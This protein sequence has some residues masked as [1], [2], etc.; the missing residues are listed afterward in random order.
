MGVVSSG[1]EGIN[2]LKIGLCYGARARKIPRLRTPHPQMFPPVRAQKADMIQPVSS[3]EINLRDALVDRLRQSG[4]DVID[5]VEDGQRVLY[6]V[7][8]PAKMQAKR[9]ALETVSVT[10]EKAH[11]PT[12]VSSADD[13]KV[14]QNLKKEKDRYKIYQI[15]E[16]LLLEMLHMRS[17]LNLR[18]VNGRK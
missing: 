2:Q 12:V 1:Y 6:E 7:N 8:S 16:R 10:S 11:Q 3:D 15:M 18:L 17:P 9:R 4:I 5:D 14:L 13:A